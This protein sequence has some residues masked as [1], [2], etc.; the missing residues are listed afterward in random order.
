M[1]LKTE[2]TAIIIIPSGGTA[3][4]SEIACATDSATNR[5]TRSFAALGSDTKSPKATLEPSTR[6]ASV[7]NDEIYRVLLISD[8]TWDSLTGR[9]ED[10]MKPARWRRGRVNL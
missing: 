3:S 8:T 9:T 5:F 10:L 2:N 4:A 1:R 7:L 6:S